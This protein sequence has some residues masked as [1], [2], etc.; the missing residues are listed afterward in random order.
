M[1]LPPQHKGKLKFL[2]Q[3]V[4]FMSWMSNVKQEFD[5]RDGTLRLWKHTGRLIDYTWL[6]Q[7]L[8]LRTVSYDIDK[9][10]HK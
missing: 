10:P 4:Y 2:I 3:D 5:F 9:E 7:G 6:T 8:F 1:A